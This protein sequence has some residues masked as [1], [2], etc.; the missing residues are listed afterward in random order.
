MNTLELILFDLDGTLYKSTEILPRSY[1]QGI[2]R[3]LE[4]QNIDCEV[5]SEEQILN[6]IGNP[7]D[8][9]YENLFPQL[10]STQ[11]KQLSREIVDE[12]TELIRKGNGS[13]I[14]GVPE[15]LGQLQK[16]YPLGLVTNA[17]IDYMDAVV[18]TYQLDQYFFRMKC[19]E[20]VESNKKARLVQDMLENAGV[21][22]E[23]TVLV[24]DRKSDYDAAQE[25]GTGFIGCEFGYSSRGE[26][27][28]AET[29]HEFRE[30][31]NHP[32]IEIPVA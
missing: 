14:T 2:E 24:G 10:T 17:R 29:I 6:Q 19:I 15:V 25:M 11:C 30:L 22:A 5:P 13:L 26:F 31:L 7:A 21:S 18:E 8:E 1:R 32:R 9:I 20:M 4:T 16:H 12:L 23:E 28:Q 3:F 27:P